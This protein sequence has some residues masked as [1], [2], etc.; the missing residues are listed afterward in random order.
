MHHPV[1]QSFTIVPVGGE[2]ST[3]LVFETVFDNGSKKDTVLVKI[4]V[5]GKYSVL[6]QKLSIKF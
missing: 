4:F 2:L 6:S 3:T 5:R 1:A